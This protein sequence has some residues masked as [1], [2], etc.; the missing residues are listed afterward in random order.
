MLAA[1]GDRDT[2]LEV[3]E[4]FRS[5]TALRFARMREGLATADLR[6]IRAQAHAIKG[7]AVQVGARSLAVLCQRIEQA[8]QDVES[9]V[10]LAEA[11][12]GEL[13]GATFRAP[14]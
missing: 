9:L 10:E 11:D 13:C 14:M 2:V 5:D 4:L 8:G 3:L 12:F 6:E 1:G 7:S